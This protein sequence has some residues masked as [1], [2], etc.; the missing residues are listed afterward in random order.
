[1]RKHGLRIKLQDQPFKILLL[2]LE[3]PGQTVSRDDLRQKLWPAD[4]FVDFDHS[5]NSSIKKLRKALGD[6]SENPRFIE[7]LHRRGYRFIA[8]VDLPYVSAVVGSEQCRSIAPVPAN[9]APDP[10]SARQPAQTSIP[11]VL[12]LARRHKSAVGVVGCAVL[13]VLS[14]A[15]FGA[16]SL[17]HRPAPIPFQN[18]TITQITNTGKATRAAVSP[19][20][21]YVLSAINDNG[22]ESIWLRNVPTGSDTQG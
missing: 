5:L 15:A 21:R 2:L 12:A 16:Y 22:L 17:L 8:P 10:L 9:A 11:A 13:I 18:F 6:D 4:T 14:A 3:H 20:G 19:D 7:T 1:M